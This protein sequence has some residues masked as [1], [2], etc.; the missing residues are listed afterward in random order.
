MR[1]LTVLPRKAAGE[2][3]GA[4]YAAPSCQLGHL[5]VELAAP[6][7]DSALDRAVAPQSQYQRG[8]R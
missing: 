6:L 8:L 5:A 2:T 1:E 3:W 4:A 7:Q